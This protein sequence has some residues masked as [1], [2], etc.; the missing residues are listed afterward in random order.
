MSKDPR[1]RD[2]SKPKRGHLF[3]FRGLPGSGKSSLAAAMV[4]AGL[5]DVVVTRD[6]IRKELAPEKVYI[7]RDKMTAADREFERLVVEMRNDRISAALIS[8]KRVA[9]ADTNLSATALRELHNIAWI[10]E[11][12]V[13][14][15]EIQ[16][17]KDLCIARDARRERPVGADIISTM[18]RDWSWQRR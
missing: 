7:S 2:E 16:A 11:S 9:S 10:Y 6:D 13:T 8:G 17:E 5:L 18:D 3:I 14:V 4:Q 1:K 12:S 15:I